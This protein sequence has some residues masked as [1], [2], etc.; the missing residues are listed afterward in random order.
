MTAS[1][2]TT[3]SELSSLRGEWDALAESAASPL[4]DHDWF[5][6]C[7]EALHDECDL[8]VVTTRDQGRLTGVAPLVRETRSPGHHLVL[9]GAARLY[10]PSGWLYSSPAALAE[11]I[12]A[13]MQMRAPIL[14]QRIPTTSSM[15]GE[16]AA[17]LRGRGLTIVRATSPSLGVDTHGSWDEFRARM[18]RRTL[19]SLSKSLA[20]AETLLGPS[21]VEELKPR[22]HDVGPLLEAFADL[23]NSGWKGRHGSSM[24][25]RADLAAFFRAYCTRVAERGRLRVT[26]L[27]YG[28]RVAAAEIAV[29]VY[30]RRWG[31]KIAYRDEL[32]PYS[33]GLQVVH[34]SVRAAFEC[35][36]NS[37]EFL[38]VAEAWQRRWQPE[39]RQC[40]LIAIYPW[41]VSGLVG[42]CRD[43]GSALL[44]R[45]SRVRSDANPSPD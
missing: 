14:L 19:S 20:S 6:S 16:L 11:L 25:Q 42:A 1:I 33:P 24:G 22:P 10:E 40:R 35:R 45:F 37:Y 34:D 26:R 12:S 30:G 38:G 23:E 39:E 44:G 21:Y 2:V 3:L 8:R 9:L 17:L 7:A 15:P 13:V 28:S 36:L 4:L 29:D 32:A 43:V 18:S 31:L 5:V 27:N 41:S